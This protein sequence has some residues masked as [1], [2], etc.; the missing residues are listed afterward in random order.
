MPKHSQSAGTHRHRSV[1]LLTA[2]LVLAL[3]SLAHARL[4][5]VQDGEPSPLRT[6][7][8]PDAALVSFQFRSSTNIE[9]VG[10]DRA[11]EFHVT[12]RVRG[13]GS[14]Y[15]IELDS[16]D[17]RDLPPPWHF[18]ADYTTYVL[19]AV[20]P[21]GEAT[22]LAEVLYED[23]RPRDI[24]V[25]TTNQ[26][27]WLMVTAEPDF[28][29]SEPSPATILV[30][31]GQESY[32]T[33]NKGMALDE[34]ATYRTHYSDYNPQPGAPPKVN[35]PTYLLQARKALAV[36]DAAIGTDKATDTE[37]D[38]AREPRYAP[39]LVAAR[40][41]LQ[42]TEQ[43]YLQEFGR[44]E[45]NLY[46]RT[47]IQF[48]ENART[49][50]YGGVPGRLLSDLRARLAASEAE[51]TRISNLAAKTQSDLDTSVNTL[52]Q[53]EAAL[54][55]ER[56][57][58]RTT[59]SQILAL[60]EQ[61]TLQDTRLTNAAERSDTLRLYDQYFCSLA[62]SELNLLGGL[63][64]NNGYFVL[65]FPA[66]TLFESGK[67]DLAPSA[68]AV[69]SRFAVLRAMLFPG[70]V[71]RF[72]G[73]TDSDGPRD[74]NQWMS[75][76]RALAVYRFFVLNDLARATSATDDTQTSDLGQ[77]LADVDT[78]LAMSFNAVRRQPRR[79]EQWM[80]SL[81]GVVVGKGPDQPI[82]DIPTDD[83]QNRR[84][85]LILLKDQRG[86]L[87]RLCGGLFGEETTDGRPRLPL[88]SVRSGRGR[89]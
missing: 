4:H 67:F 7:E 52:A 1:A 24:E 66:S 10:T 72:E 43:L 5:P 26:A 76:Q 40:R 32:D 80:A 21:G 75:E 3:G 22:N 81:N 69:L 23:G 37:P 50:F 17:V 8:V 35:T 9:L 47:S 56:Q 54:D 15:R 55:R 6:I 30:S 45:I 83:P 62:E 64:E 88:D 39:L 89:P 18:G 14:H 11:P 84:V 77:I 68:H 36:A 33:N 2:L 53:M 78:M 12:L 25:S 49:H 87:A 63:A 42:H 29:V 16:R 65:T 60:R 73:H 44:D 82:A 41:H 59:E 28:A 70:A 71:I 46:A 48:A 34:T 61:I 31:T 86:D 38:I 57:H 20:A 51:E 58:T 27:F 19:W 85:T 79:R 13:R 74:Y